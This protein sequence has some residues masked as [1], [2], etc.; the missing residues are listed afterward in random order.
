MALAKEM[1]FGGGAMTLRKTTF[2]IMPFSI[3]TCSI[4]LLRIMSFSITTDSIS[5]KKL[6]TQ[7][8]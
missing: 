6:S 7:H 3:T 8:K 1:V 5:I 4:T 2:S